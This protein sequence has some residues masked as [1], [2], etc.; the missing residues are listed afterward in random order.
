MTVTF[1]PFSVVAICVDKRDSIGNADVRRSKISNQPDSN[2]K[3]AKYESNCSRPFGSGSPLLSRQT[4][5][6]IPNTTEPYFKHKS[7]RSLPIANFTKSIND[8][9]QCFASDCIFTF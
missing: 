6:S 9:T 1:R 2:S 8:N 4:F 3:R 5:N 7:M